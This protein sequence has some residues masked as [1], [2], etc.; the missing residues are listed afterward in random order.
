M[1][2]HSCD[3]WKIRGMP[4]PVSHPEE[5]DEEEDQPDEKGLPIPAR[6]VQDQEDVGDADAERRRRPYLFPDE[7]EVPSAPPVV[8][9]AKRPERPRVPTPIRPGVPVRQFP[10]IPEIA[11]VASAMQ[12]GIVP[13]PFNA[14]AHFMFPKPLSRSER[15]EAKPPGVRAPITNAE[16]IA[17]QD[18]LGAPSFARSFVPSGI[19]AIGETVAAA[20]MAPVV[21]T[22]GV[23]VL[24][25]EFANDFKWLA[26]AA[27]V[28]GTAGAAAAFAK[29]FG[30]GT[31]PSTSIAPARPGG[32]GQGFRVNMSRRL[33]ELRTAGGGRRET[34]PFFEGEPTQ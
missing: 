24:E 30:G 32:A 13:P 16:L 15:A 21:R 34:Q 28:L 20:T 2:F 12:K 22:S 8:V 1:S 26:L 5:E 23:N 33:R 19:G 9:P 27:I 7:L 31:P 18:Q 6:R 14:E 11:A 25:E 17:A 29:G 4:C 10:A 3:R